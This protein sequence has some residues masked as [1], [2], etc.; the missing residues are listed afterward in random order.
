MVV[1]MYYLLCYNCK[2]YVKDLENLQ[3]LHKETN[4]TF[5]VIGQSSDHFEPFCK[6]RGNSH[7]IYI[8]LDRKICKTEREKR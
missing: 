1:F 3:Q 5:K 2:E 6:L 8:D 7:E 4:V